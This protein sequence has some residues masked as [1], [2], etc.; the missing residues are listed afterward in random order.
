MNTHDKNTTR[1]CSYI[2]KRVEGIPALI[3]RLNAAAGYLAEYGWF[4]ESRIERYSRHE[5]I[6]QVREAIGEAA[7]VWGIPATVR[8]LGALERQN[9]WYVSGWNHN[10][11]QL[12]EEWQRKTSWEDTEWNDS[13]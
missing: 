8:A 11:T 12:C 2:Q 7:A 6:D 10:V 5:Q 4:D 3:E 1:A 13:E 9:A